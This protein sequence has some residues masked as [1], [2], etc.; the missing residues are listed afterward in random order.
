MTMINRW[1]KSLNLV[2]VQ[3]CATS[4]IGSETSGGYIFLVRGKSNSKIKKK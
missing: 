1:R 2:L 3:E 4:R